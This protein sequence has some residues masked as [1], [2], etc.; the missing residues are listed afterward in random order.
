MEKKKFIEPDPD[1]KDRLMKAFD[2]KY[3]AKRTTGSF[4]LFRLMNY[5]IP[6]Y[7]AGMAASVLLFFVF[8]L[9]LQ[10][11]N[12]SAEVAVSDTIYIDKPVH[13]KDT[14]WMEKPGNSEGGRLA[15]NRNANQQPRVH[16]PLTQEENDLYSL[17]M[18]E[19]MGR[20]SVISALSPERSVAG[21]RELLMLVEAVH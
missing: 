4:S 5:P 17:Q 3:P 15:T 20:I 14:I 2:E 11:H 12:T 8:Y 21:D 16:T 13:I 19:S 10:H 1:V 18:K 9:L 6:L 7:Q